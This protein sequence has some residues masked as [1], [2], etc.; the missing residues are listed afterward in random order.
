MVGMMTTFILGFRLFSGSKML[1]SERVNP[2]EPMSFLPS[3]M[4]LNIETFKSFILNIVI[5]VK[6]GNLLCQLFWAKVKKHLLNHSPMA[7]IFD[8]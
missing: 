6:I 2:I 4:L 1:V 5:A 7:T 3:E 8:M